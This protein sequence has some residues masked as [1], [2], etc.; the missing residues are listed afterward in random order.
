MVVELGPDVRA[1]GIYPGGQSGNP[2]SPR[3]DDRLSQWLRGGLA[4]LR[5]PRTASEL[6]PTAVLLLRRMR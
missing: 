2:A 5:F 3:Y 4:P 6:A 1:W